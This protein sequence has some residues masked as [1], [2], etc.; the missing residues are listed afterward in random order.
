MTRWSLC[1]MLAV[2][3]PAVAAPKSGPTAAQKEADRH[4]K[5]GVAL[6]KENKY[7]E[8]L[9]EFR[10]LLADKVPKGVSLVDELLAERRIEA[11]RE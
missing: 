3:T 11:E 5:S 9:A 1:I 6:Y 10:S 4:F 2:A 8:A 7:S